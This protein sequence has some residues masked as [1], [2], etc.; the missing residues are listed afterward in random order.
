MGMSAALAGAGGDV[1]TI[2]QASLG[3]GTTMTG[4]A[5][6]SGTV[7]PVYAVNSDN[8]LY[9]VDFP[10]GATLIGAIGGGAAGQ[11]NSLSFAPDGQMY[12]GGSD[13]TWWRI[14]PS[15]GAGAQ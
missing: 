10:T 12:A 9:Q 1:T 11:L 13:G 3:L 2:L 8:N 14:D 5:I 7:S 6:Q 4:L 15:T